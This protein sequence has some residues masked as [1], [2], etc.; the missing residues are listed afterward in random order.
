MKRS[1]SAES[2]LSLK[3]LELFTVR[4]RTH[5]LCVHALARAH[6]HRDHGR[7]TVAAYY[8]HEARSFHRELVRLIRKQR[9]VMGRL[10]A[11][12]RELEGEPGLTGADRV[13]LML[14]RTAAADLLSLRS[15]G[16]HRLAQLR[17][18]VRS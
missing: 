17:E 14:V 1:A 5:A 8:V 12:V 9:D 3:L 16:Q 10:V 11:G 13:K 6:Y 7:R 18:A 4:W 2:G 15:P